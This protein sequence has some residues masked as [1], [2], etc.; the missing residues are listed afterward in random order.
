MFFFARLKVPISRS[1]SPTGGILN[2]LNVESRG[3]QDRL[4]SENKPTSR[5]PGRVN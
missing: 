1:A 5:V 3:G 4:A 2:V